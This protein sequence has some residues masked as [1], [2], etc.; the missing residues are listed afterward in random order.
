MEF[1]EWQEDLMRELVKKG[2]PR[3]DLFSVMLVL[4]KEEKGKKMLASLRESG[5]L[6]PDEIREMA[7]RIA[8]AED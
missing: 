2:L 4:T 5:V 7:G 3:E 1:V 8:F 6:T